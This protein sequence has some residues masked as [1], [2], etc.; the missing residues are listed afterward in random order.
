MLGSC[1]IASDN[2]IGKSHVQWINR[3]GLVKTAMHVATTTQFS[4]WCLHRQ[5]L[6][7]RSLSVWKS[8]DLTS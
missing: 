6:G 7:F 5:R 8:W 3:V 1:S 2:T 4:V